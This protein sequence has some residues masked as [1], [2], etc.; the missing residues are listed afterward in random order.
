MDGLHYLGL[1]KVT[2]NTKSLVVPVAP[3]ALFTLFTI[4]TV[5]WGSSFWICTVAKL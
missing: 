3:S 5:G 4:F 1:L 2:V